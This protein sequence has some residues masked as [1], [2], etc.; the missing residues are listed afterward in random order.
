MTKDLRV[1]LAAVLIA[2]QNAAAQK[3]RVSIVGCYSDLNLDKENGVV[4][5]TG[6]FRIRPSKGKYEAFFTELI[7]DGGSY[8]KT[9]KVR[10]FKVNTAKRKVAYDAVLH[11]GRFSITLSGVTGRISQG[12][13]KMNWRGSG[14]AI[15][16]ANPYL[17][18][19]FR[20]C[21]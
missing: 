11:D 4:T 3:P 6:S 10:N 12:G 7:G 13:I 18:R 5:G 17:R 21:E 2:P 9:A 14:T 20:D 15:G 19:R 1:I 16:D 8:A